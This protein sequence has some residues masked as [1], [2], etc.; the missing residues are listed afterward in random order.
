MCSTEDKVF[1]SIGNESE[2]PRIPL[3][4]ALADGSCLIRSDSIPI[5]FTDANTGRQ[6]T[7]KARTGVKLE[8]PKTGKISAAKLYIEYTL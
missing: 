3:M 4:K 2:V 8:T 7:V 6:K 1:G 5:T